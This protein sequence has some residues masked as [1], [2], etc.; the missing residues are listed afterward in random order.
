MIYDTSH[1]ACGVLVI[2]GFWPCRVTRKCFGMLQ[3]FETGL[4]PQV[5]NLGMDR[6][7]DLNYAFLR[8]VQIQNDG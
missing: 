7:L 8:L 4:R 2:D 1:R 3:Y 5:C 6:V